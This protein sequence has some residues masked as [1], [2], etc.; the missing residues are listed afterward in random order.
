MKDLTKSN[1][2]AIVRSYGRNGKQDNET[3]KT[4]EKA[5]KAWAENYHLCLLASFSK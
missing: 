4:L 2:E 3:K 1:F 5:K